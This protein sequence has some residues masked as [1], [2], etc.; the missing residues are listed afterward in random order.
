MYFALCVIAVLS[1]LALCAA[2]A[3]IL[4]QVVIVVRVVP[5]RVKVLLFGVLPLWVIPLRGAA[6]RKITFHDYL[7]SHEGHRYIWI[8][9][10]IFA[11]RFVL[12]HRGS[13]IFRYVVLSPADP[14]AFMERLVAAGATREQ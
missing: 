2:L 9:N 14:D 4:L 7:R 11:R 12:I 3:N 13:G 6:V 10:R 8:R 1:G 5:P